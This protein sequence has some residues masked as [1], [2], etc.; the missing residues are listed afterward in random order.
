MRMFSATWQRA[1]TGKRAEMQDV[2]LLQESA[3]SCGK[4]ICAGK[5]AAPRAPSAPCPGRPRRGLGGGPAVAAAVLLGVFGVLGMSGV[6]DQYAAAVTI[7]WVTVGDA[8]NTS[9][10]PWGAVADAFQIMKYEFTNSQYVEFL[11]AVDP[12]GTNPN[13]IFNSSMNSDNIGGGI[14]FNSGAASGS[15]YAVKT[16][17]GDKPVNYVTWFDAARVSNWLHNGQ[18][19][20]STETGAYTLN[21]Q[22]TGTAPAVNP[23]AVYYLPT[24]NQW[25]KAAFYKGG[26]TNAGYWDYAT[27]SDSDPTHVTADSNGNGSAG[28]I[29]NFAN[30]QRVADWN[31]ENGN[32]TTVG[33]N[34]GPSAYG[35][36]DMSGN[37]KEWTNTG[38]SNKAIRGGDY[39][40]AAQFIRSTFTFDLAPDTPAATIGFR[41]AAVP[42]PSTLVMGL[43]GI[44]CAGWGAYRRR[45]AR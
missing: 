4:R 32:V 11:N 29:G 17:F 25:Y 8:G 3:G 41:L 26:G 33:T 2:G 10:N 12:N 43:A 30:Y 45:R 24:E 19:S 27:Q 21:G 9:D 37:V 5:A 14:S 34:G 22:T 36:F 31:N 18:G 28:G 35:T 15:K 6:A 1:A 40:G 38:T 16:N 23:G 20:G 39:V 44:A 13:A 42:E 7:D